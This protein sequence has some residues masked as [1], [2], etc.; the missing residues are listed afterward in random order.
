MNHKDELEYLKKND[1]ILYY[2]LTGNPTGVDSDS[3]GVGFIFFVLIVVIAIT[4]IY[5]FN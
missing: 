2:E 1:P 5:Y 3:S 4:I